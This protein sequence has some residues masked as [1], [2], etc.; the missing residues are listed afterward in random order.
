MNLHSLTLKNVLKS[1]K[2]RLRLVFNKANTICATLIVLTFSISSSCCRDFDKDFKALEPEFDITLRCLLKNGFEGVP[3][4]VPIC[5]KQIGDTLVYFQFRDADKLSCKPSVRCCKFKLKNLDIDSIKH[6]LWPEYN[7]MIIS[8]IDEMEGK[9]QRF[10]LRDCKKNYYFD[11]S[12]DKNDSTIVL[13]Y[14][15]ICKEC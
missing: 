6:E 1:F 8:E 11:V 10:Y 2:V 7:Y 5:A 3:E 9:Y 12:I 15:Y 14:H 4:D 13:F